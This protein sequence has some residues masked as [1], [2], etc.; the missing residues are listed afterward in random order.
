MTR[1]LH[2][3]TR[4]VPDDP[5][6]YRSGW[7]AVADSVRAQGGHAWRFQAVDRGDRYIEFIEWTSDDDLPACRDVAAARADLDAYG[8]VETCEIWREES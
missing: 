8:P 3:T 1:R 4:S 5:E 7:R 2:V 6:G